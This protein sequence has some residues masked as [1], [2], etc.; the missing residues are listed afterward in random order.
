MEFNYRYLLAE[1]T[2]RRSTYP[3]GSKPPE[4]NPQAQKGRK[5]DRL[6]VVLVPSGGAVV[7]DQRTHKHSA[8]NGSLRLMPVDCS[9]S[10][11]STVPISTAFRR[12]A[13][14][15]PLQ[16]FMNRPCPQSCI[17]V[18]PPPDVRWHASELAYLYASDDEF[19]PGLA[20]ADGVRD[21]P[22]LPSSLLLVHDDPP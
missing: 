12:S 19:R 21:T 2:G 7:V 15:N 20:D 4:L 10:P 18:H 6:R 16:I 1:S 13:C 3:C 22:C 11:T 14:F 9:Q 5:P 8:Q 17:N